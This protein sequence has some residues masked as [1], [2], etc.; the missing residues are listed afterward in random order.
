MEEEG[1]SKMTEGE[2]SSWANFGGDEEKK[3][4]SS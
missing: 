4:F 3:K 2:G 1:N